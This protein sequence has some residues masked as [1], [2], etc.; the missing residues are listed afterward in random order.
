M[1]AVESGGGGVSAAAAAAGIPRRVISGCCHQNQG[2]RDFEI[3][4][5]KYEGPQIRI[6][7]GLKL[8]ADKP[9]DELKRKNK[10]VQGSKFG[11]EKRKMELGDRGFEQSM[12]M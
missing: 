9:I 4:V 7:K 3:R 5:L 6:L 1:G 12:I 8:L 10:K 11:R 2:F